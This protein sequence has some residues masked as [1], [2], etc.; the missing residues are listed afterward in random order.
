LNIENSVNTV[1]GFITLIRDVSVSMESKHFRI[2]NK[3]QVFNVFL[4][5]L[6]LSE[7]GSVIL[8]RIR[9]SITIV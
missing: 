6:Y 2:I 7:A 4:I 5:N 8:A 1:I 3:R 9:V